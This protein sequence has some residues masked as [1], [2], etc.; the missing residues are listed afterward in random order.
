MNA[1][2]VMLSVWLVAALIFLFWLDTK[3]GKK[4]LNDFWPYARKYK[5]LYYLGPAG[6][7]ALMSI[8]ESKTINSAKHLLIYSLGIMIS[9]C[10]LFVG[11]V[12]TNKKKGK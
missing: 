11:L 10:S 3:R 6:F 7:I 8:S 2:V 5:K 4:W 12:L 9:L 1:I